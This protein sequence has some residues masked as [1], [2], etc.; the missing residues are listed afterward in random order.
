MTQRR[1]DQTRQLS[2]RYVKAN[3]F[4]HNIEFS[5]LDSRAMTWRLRNIIF[6]C[7]EGFASNEGKPEKSLCDWTK[8][9]FSQKRRKHRKNVKAWKRNKNYSLFIVGNVWQAHG[10]SSSLG[11]RR[12]SPEK[13]SVCRLLP[14]NSWARNL[15]NDVAQSLLFIVDFF[16]ANL[17]F[18]VIE[19]KLFN[20]FFCNYESLFSR[21]AKFKSQGLQNC[22]KF[23][24]YD[25]NCNRQ[26]CPR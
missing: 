17:H 25:V 15:I 10:F 19:K 12:N 9:I 22:T 6:S 5:L 23:I 16:N 3:Y 4:W 2:I 8:K 1:M 24:V 7:R 20:E 26:M 21:E 11:F 13:L 14:E 18:D